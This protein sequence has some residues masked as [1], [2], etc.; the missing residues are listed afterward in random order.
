[1]GGEDAFRKEPINNLP[2][3]GSGKVI[4]KYAADNIRFFFMYE[5]FIAE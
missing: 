2:Q 1:M 3:A 5:N 4:L